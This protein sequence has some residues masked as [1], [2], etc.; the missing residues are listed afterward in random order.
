MIIFIVHSLAAVHGVVGR[1]HL[2]TSR[3]ATPQSLARTSS[4][5]MALSWVE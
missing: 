4:A 2:W 1:I 3:S 5:I